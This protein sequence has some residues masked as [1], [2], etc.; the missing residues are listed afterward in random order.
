MNRMNHRKS[1]I[2]Q[3]VASALAM[4]A[5]LAAVAANAQMTSAIDESQQASPVSP[6]LLLAQAGGAPASSQAAKGESSDA[7]QMQSVVVTARRRTERIQDV[8]LSITA[9]SGDGL[10]AEG[11]VRIADV[12][13]ANVSFLGPENNATPNFSVRGIQSQNRQN[14]GFDSGVGVYVDGIY[15]GRGAGFNQES[16]DVE[17]VEFLRGP[18][19][20]LF[21]KNSIAGAISVTTKQPGA[22]REAAVSADVGSDNQRRFSGYMS[23]PLGDDTI[24]ASLSGYSSKRDGYINNLATGSNFG[25]EDVTAVRAKVLFT[26][27]SRL[28]ITL[29]ADSLD[30]KS[31]ATTGKIESGYGFV[32]GAAD[33]TNNTNLLPKAYRKLQGIGATINYDLGPNLRLTSIT[34]ARKLSTDR[35]N[36]P[37]FGPLEIINSTKSYNQKQWSQEL[38]ISSVSPSTFEYVA[39]I[40][41][42]NQKVD[43]NAQSCFGPTAPGIAAVRGL[44]GSTFGDIE[45]TSTAVFGNLDWNISSV[46]TLTGGLRLMKEDKGLSYEQKVQWPA[47]ISPALARETD[48]ISSKNVT[49]MIS[50][51][52][53]VTPKSMVYGTVSKGFRSGGWNVDNIT[54]GGPTTFRQTRFDDE[55]LVN[56]ELGTKNSLMNGKLNVNLALFRMDY[57]DIQVTQLVP[58]L[59]GGGALLGV[60]TNGGKARSQGAEIEIAARPMS[61]LKV[62][63]GLGFVEAKYTEYTDKSGATPL[64]FNG[65]YL[66]YAP[67]ANANLS[68]SYSFP[69][70]DGTLTLLGAYKFTD[71]YYNGRENN[72]TQELPS[73]GIFNTRIT[74]AT[75]SDHVEVALYSNNLFDKRYIVNYGPGGFAAPLGVGTNK[76][77]EYGRGRTIGLTGTYRF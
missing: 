56:F 3:S 30:D 73:Y 38:R 51:R 1:L 46:L 35:N 69:I 58:A 33:F 42:Y 13:I 7:D 8:P 60:V 64:S 41:H 48:T 12:P 31:I 62:S 72:A 26:P 75:D 59:G 57:K 19:G 24:R 22:T 28:N 76:W 18:Q 9:V 45:T 4:M 47:F 39:G 10:R 65:K 74:Y 21:G 11:A 63:V 53:K 71:S 54:V 68:A 55:S 37:D 34:S 29:A 25:T 36:D 61:G 44:C 40:Y 16:F 6:S 15:M 23:S 32:Q 49:P 77:V 67:R 52:W 5:T 17:R 20:T 27:N 66:N 50:A 70:K 43:S 2:G 14:V